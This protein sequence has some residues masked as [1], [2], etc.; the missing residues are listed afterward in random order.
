MVYNTQN[1]WV[2]GLCQSSG[3][4][5][6]GKYNFS[7]I[8]SVYFLIHHRRYSTIY[9]NRVIGHENSYVTELSNPLNVRRRL[10]RQ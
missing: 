4:L 3:I 8:G 10:K 6:I 2:P 1:Y 7:E 9:C 5:N